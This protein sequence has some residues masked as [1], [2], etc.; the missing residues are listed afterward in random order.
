M[1]TKMQATFFIQKN[2]EKIIQEYG[3]RIL[4][5]SKAIKQQKTCLPVLLLALMLIQYSQRSRNL[6]K[7]GIFYPKNIRLSHSKLD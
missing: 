2:R 3:I 5:A 6:I 7:P 1:E 4:L